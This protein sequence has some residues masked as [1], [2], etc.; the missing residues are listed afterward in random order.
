MSSPLVW[1]PF[2]NNFDYVGT[3]GSG[4]GGVQTLSDNPDTTINPDGSGNIQLVGYVPQQGDAEFSTV[5]AGSSIAEINP[6]STARWIVDP[7][8]FNGTHTDITTAISSATN[9]DTID[10]F[11]GSYTITNL[12]LKN[13]VNLNGLSNCYG[14][15][16][17]VIT[18]KF[19]D[20]GVTCNCK[21][22]NLV[23]ETNGDHFI[24]LSG[25]ASSLVNK[26]CYYGA[27]N[28]NGMLIGA[29]CTITSVDCT[30]DLSGLG[31]GFYSGAGAA[32]F[33]S[34]NFTNSGGSTASSA[35]S[36]TNIFYNCIM[37]S[38]IINSG[39]GSVLMR[40]TTIDTSA[41]NS[42]AIS[43]VGS[44][45]STITESNVLSGTATALVVGAGT[46]VNAI[47]SNFKT[48]N[49]NAISGSGTL[50]QGGL[51]FSGAS[52][53]INVTTINN[54]I[55]SG[56]EIGEL[57]Y[58]AN[59]GSAGNAYP[60]PQYLLCDGS[61]YSQ[62][63]YPALFNRLGLLNNGG[64]FWTQNQFGTS[65][66][67]AVTFGNGIF[68]AGANNG[69]IYTST[70]AVTWTSRTSGTTSSFS[71]LTY[72]GMYVFANNTSPTYLATS[73]DAITWV[74]RAIPVYSPISSLSYG[75]GLYVGTSSVGA[76]ITSTDAITWSTRQPFI[77][78]AA[79]SAQGYKSYIFANSLYLICGSA[80]II[81]T[82]T[83]NIN[84]IGRN[85]ASTTINLN[86]I[87]YAN[88]AYIASGGAGQLYSSTDAVT[89][90]GRTTGTGSTIY[91]LT[92]SSVGGYVF[93]TGAGGIST[94]TD[95][96]TWAAQTSGSTSNL[97]AATYGLTYV[98]A[99]AGGA[100]LTSVA[101]TVWAAQTSG[102]TSSIY[103]VTYLN[104][105]YLYAGATGVL[106][107]STN[108]VTWTARTSAV[109]L[110]VFSIAYGNGAYVTVG[111]S[112]Q[113]QSS[114]DGVTWTVR[115]SGTTSTLTG[116]LY[117]TA[118]FA[119][120][121]NTIVTSTD[122]TT[123]SPYTTLYPAQSSAY[124][125]SVY[126]IAGVGG[127]LWTAT[128]A[129]NWVS[130]TSSAGTSISA[131]TY[132]TQFVYGTINGG[133]AT[134]TNG[135]AWAAQSSTVTTNIT[136]ITYSSGVYLATIGTTTNLTITSDNAIVWDQV[137]TASTYT[138]LVSSAAGNGLM[139]IVGQIA[140]TTGG[141]Q[142]SPSTYTYNS[143]TQFQVP[144]D[145]QAA[146][147]TQSTINFQ[148]SL[149]IKAL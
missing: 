113:V 94:S 123:W 83:D 48:S 63:T 33:E 7:L 75:N 116:V 134:S 124:G 14:G 11:A 6:M 88:G 21:L 121:S 15:G 142:Y 52:S 95:G 65:S 60:N 59:G 12:A 30:G 39:A 87:F 49:S 138:A 141:I 128:D 10:I 131:L 53:Y 127:N 102:T 2:T 41:I 18:G 28:A 17:V 46:T 66:V 54:L 64:T 74:Q 86:G 70:N 37:Q 5:V 45:T 61:T 90:T 69:A 109:T 105:L 23:F 71:S 103:T 110:S 68:V 118:F 89:W 126:M 136:S 35:T 100:I 27:S 146:I 84:F 56:N 129:K 133:I 79:V 77:G 78:P 40:N 149:Y 98:V 101:G 97:Y 114:T 106:G 29:G 58:F 57:S 130:Q 140:G 120:G 13:G 50:N 148:R 96:T 122:G 82:S 16:Q 92:Y 108:A 99:G 132:G 32:I 31:V 25:S 104:S 36:G 85:A 34:C 72:G 22:D 115:I 111:A 47:L 147:T 76:V 9:G 137:A 93:C 43:I 26:N 24:S 145:A 119:G 38:P 81:S 55:L 42:T 8:G 44:G 107:T 51:V 117:S 112:G 3:G 67:N 73:T 144:T 20:N 139:V 143:S 125:N 62:A 4:G 135:V 91:G 80:N 19:I 1:N